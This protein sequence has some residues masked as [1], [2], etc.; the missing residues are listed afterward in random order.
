MEQSWQRPDDN[1]DYVTLDETGDL[2]DQDFTEGNAIP[3]DEEETGLEDL[4]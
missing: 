2:A 1:T 3:S 4:E